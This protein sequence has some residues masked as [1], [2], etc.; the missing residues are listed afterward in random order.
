MNW[1][2]SSK[3]RLVLTGFVTAVILLGGRRAKADFIFGEPVNLGPPVNPAGCPNI[4]A[5]GMELYFSSVR[6]G[7]YGQDDLWVT[8]RQRRNDPWGEPV[9]LGSTVNSSYQEWFSTISQD[10]L[11]LYFSS[12][13]PGGSGGWDLW[14]T[15]RGTTD[16]DWGAP[17][18]LGQT[19]NSSADEYQPNILAD[20]CTLLLCS[21]RPGGYGGLDIWITK[22]DTKNDTWG[23]LVNLGPP[24]NT[25]AEDG[26]PSMSLDGLTLFFRTDRPGGFG[27]GDIWLTTRATTNDPWREPINLGPTV[28]TSSWECGPSISRDGATLYFHSNRPVGMVV[29]TSGRCQS[30]QWWTLTATE[31]STVPTCA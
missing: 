26:R 29:G 10:G 15:T 5:D 2:N 27:G 13:R 21:S 19:I 23:T 18:N 11:S 12:T 30:L 9:N 1:L 3:K 14:M 4:S 22:R 16:K 24:I 17:V 6:S 20:G 8:R 31:S 25:S 7:G 28:N